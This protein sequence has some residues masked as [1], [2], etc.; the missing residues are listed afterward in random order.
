MG[1]AIWGGGSGAQFLTGPLDIQGEQVVKWKSRLQGRSPDWRYKSGS[2]HMQTAPCTICI[3]QK[4][5]IS[6]QRED[7]KLCPLIIKKQN[8]LKQSM[9]LVFQNQ[10][11][12]V[13]FL[14]VIL[15]SASDSTED[16]QPGTTL[17]HQKP[18]QNKK[19]GNIC[20]PIMICLCHSKSIL[21]K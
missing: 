1:G 11:T 7:F 6:Y 14:Y 2:H 18:N 13:Q 10:M 21:I 5:W 16:R 9:L 19:T 12:V 4:F 8:Q 3:R 15:F 20:M 17:D